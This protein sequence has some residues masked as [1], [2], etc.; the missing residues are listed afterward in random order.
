[1]QLLRVSVVEFA[2]RNTGLQAGTATCAHCTSL[3]L[4]CTLVAWYGSAYALLS[5]V[6]R[7][8]WCE[9]CREVC[10]FKVP[11]SEGA[12]SHKDG[13]KE[14]HCSVPGRERLP[15]RDTDG[16]E[17]LKEKQGR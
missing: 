11:M 4:P 1:M 5:G 3:E 13:Y 15:L 9:A 2:A 14:P 17:P 10:F 7:I 12:C 8:D 6:T 16:K